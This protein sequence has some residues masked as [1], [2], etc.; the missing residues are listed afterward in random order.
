MFEYDNGVRVFGLTR[1]QP[2]CCNNTSDYIMG[3]KGRCDL[4]NY[5][6][7]GETNWHYEGPGGNM[8]DLEHKKLFDAIRAGQ[9]DQQR[10]LTCA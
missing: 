10:P 7:D 3:T 8:Y 2:D 6:I 9:A 1:D 5:R 4:L